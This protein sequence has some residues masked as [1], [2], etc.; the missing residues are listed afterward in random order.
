MVL[1]RL[2]GAC[3]CVTVP[4]RW[5][6]QHVG[7]PRA[8]AGDATGRSSRVRRVAALCKSLWLLGLGLDISACSCVLPGDVEALCSA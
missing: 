3:A 1:P 8:Q 7:R 4:V 2:E 5:T 6:R